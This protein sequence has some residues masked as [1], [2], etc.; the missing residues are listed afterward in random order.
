MLKRFA[1]F[2]V[3]REMSLNLLQSLFVVAGKDGE[4]DGW[5]YGSCVQPWHQG[6]RNHGARCQGDG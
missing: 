1:C 2:C 6:R 3:Y 4:R 5:S